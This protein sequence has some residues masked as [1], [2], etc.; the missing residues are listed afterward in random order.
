MPKSI[1]C[2]VSICCFLSA[3]P[4]FAQVAGESGG[5]DL[6]IV[7]QGKT[8]A[9][10]VLS[11]EAGE[12]EKQA[13]DDLVHYIELMTG[14]KPALANT[15]EAAQSALAGSGPLLIVGQAAIKADPSL[16][17]A[18]K[19]AAKANPTLRADAIALR[20]KGN[21]VLLA[22]NHDEAHYYAAA[23][24]LRRWGCRWYIPTELGECVPEHKSLSVGQLDYA[25]GSPFEVR[26]YWISW[27]GDTTGAREFKRRNMMNDVSVPNGHILAKY[28]K[29]LAPQGKSHWN[30]PITAD[31][32][33]DHVA[34][35]V[36]PIY[37]EGRHVQLGMEDGLYDS[38][39]PG[40]QELIKLQYDEYFMR[41][42]VTDAFLVFY[43]KV[44]QRLM[45]AA[46]E[47]N[48]KI[49]FLAYANMTLPPVREISAARPLVAYLAPIDI[50][51]IHHMDDPKSAPRR[52]LKEMLYGWAKVMD[53]RVVIYDYDQGMLVWRDV[54]NPS[55]YSFRHDIKHYQQTGILGIATE[56]RNAIGTTFIN[57]H[58]RGQL[59][60]NPELDVDAHL[61]EFYEK[62]YGPAAEPMAD[63]WNAIFQAWQDT[64][65]TEHE[66]FVFQAIYTKE[67]IDLLGKKL[68]EAEKIAAPLKAKKQPA[69]N[70]RL[71]LDRMKFTRLS[72]DILQ[73][74]DQMVTAAATNVDY[75]TAA[76]AGKRGLATR[77]ELTD[78]NGIFTTYRNYPERGYA[79][80]PGE[81]KQYEEL[82]PFTDG[83]KGTLVAKLPLVWNFRRDVD[84]QGEKQHWERQT[85]D[86]TWWN[87]LDDPASLENR[88]NNPG[89]WEQVRT[90]LYLQAQGLVTKDF[91]S[92][93]GHGWYNT[94]IELTADQVK[95]GVH[96]RF[97]GMFNESWLY[98]NGKQVA[99]REL[100]AMWW[101]NDY[102]FEW[103]VDLTGHLKPGENTLVVRIDNPHHFGGM[104]RR[105][106]LYRRTN[107][108]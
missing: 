75:K 19:K 1:T 28:T 25:Y 27:V 89:A 107:G 23:D 11:P 13:A 4:L 15:N 18:L 65:V 58:I 48:A 8:S 96:I 84:N 41:Q 49:G 14:A 5:D 74:Y 93:T 20:R 64:I 91:Q 37:K 100:R 103:D 60:W 12:W 88:Q 45:K 77:E 38:D 70:E 63:Y 94:T 55:I 40:D 105:P 10:V 72:Y 62:F 46:P 17:A 92:Y 85:V 54:P 52:E 39:H 2:F 78:M 56:S 69:R 108:E 22:G 71:V 57:L 53:G 79:W 30:V 66:Y 50:D 67:L 3:G 81:V 102:R 59:M 24:L 61:G 16:A 86:L 31:K 51:P 6:V 21:R 44:A 73:A 80:W 29:D 104:F 47:S 98:A 76:A 26:N 42:S 90:D 106:F 32:T 33:A 7:R 36:L 68:A 35:H 9:T 87:S 99:H 101:Y 82:L 83:T 95:E 34:A 43:N 97:P